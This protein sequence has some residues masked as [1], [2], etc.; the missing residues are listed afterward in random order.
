MGD[1]PK[2]AFVRVAVPV[3]VEQGQ[4]HGG[5]KLPAGRFIKGPFDTPAVEPGA[6]EPEAESVGQGQRGEAGPPR[7]EQSLAVQPQPKPFSHLAK[8]RAAQI[9]QGT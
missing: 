8:A 2:G 7:Q 3:V 9:D 1:R 5:G 4:R 6:Q